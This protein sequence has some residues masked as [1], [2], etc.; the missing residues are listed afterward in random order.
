MRFLSF[1]FLFLF[2]IFYDYALSMSSATASAREGDESSEDL[3]EIL[4][5]RK[6]G[7]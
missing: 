2:A 1:A 4:K 6:G 3:N 7:R 5:N